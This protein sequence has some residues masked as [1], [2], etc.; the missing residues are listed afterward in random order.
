VSP[1]R[2]SPRSAPSAIGAVAFAGRAE[3]AL[4]ATGEHARKRT[5]EARDEL[6]PQERQ[7]ARLAQSGLSNAEIAERLFISPRTVEYHLG[8]VFAKLGI[9]KR[10]ELDTALAPDAQFGLGVRP[11]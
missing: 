10:R 9:R 3:R 5:V 4:R 11:G 7:I 2:S 1:R 6:T 8:K